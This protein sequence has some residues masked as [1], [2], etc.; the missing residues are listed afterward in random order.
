MATKRPSFL[1]RQK[2]QKRNARAQEKR[3][4]RRGRKDIRGTEGDHSSIPDLATEVTGI[5]QNTES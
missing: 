4:A 2:E 3:E 5:D 1:K